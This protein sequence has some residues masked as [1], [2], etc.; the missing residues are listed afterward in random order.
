MQLMVT[1]AAGVTDTQICAHLRVAGHQV[2]PM[3]VVETKG[4]V[5]P[6]LRDE[7]AVRRLFEEHRPEGLHQI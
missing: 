5:C 7:S 1:D 3:D 4:V 2:I 6:D